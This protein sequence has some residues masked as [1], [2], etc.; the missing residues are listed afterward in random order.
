ME[1]EGI[2]YD[3]IGLSYYPWWHGPLEQLSRNLDELAERYGRDLIVVETAYPWTFRAREGFPL[4]V[5]RSMRHCPPRIRPR[6]RG[7]RRT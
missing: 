2:D 5:E 3:V 1:A 6:R 4:I 7:R